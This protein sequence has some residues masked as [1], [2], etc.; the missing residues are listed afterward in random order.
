M[1][2]KFKGSKQENKNEFTFF[3]PGQWVANIT[4]M[5][6][7]GVT[8]IVTIATTV[9]VTLL[10]IFGGLWLAYVYLSMNIFY[11]ILAVLAVDIT[12][13]VILRVVFL[14]RQG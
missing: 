13:G 3:I 11:I 2:T 8:N 9:I 10:V 7:E 4:W 6:T 14:R 12:L 1:K 5:I